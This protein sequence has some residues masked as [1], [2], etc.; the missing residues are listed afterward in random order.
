M[1]QWSHCWGDWSHQREDPAGGGE[2]KGAFPPLCPIMEGGWTAA[3][4]LTHAHGRLPHHGSDI[5]RSS[6]SLNTV[7]LAATDNQLLYKSRLSLS[8]PRDSECASPREAL[9]KTRHQGT[10]EGFGLRGHENTNK[11]A[12]CD[13]GS[14]PA[15]VATIWLRDPK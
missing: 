14:G 2:R 13:L 9:Y 5:Q 4:S 11:M 8:V 7:F 15:S 1:G 10:H 6:G 12:A 3:N